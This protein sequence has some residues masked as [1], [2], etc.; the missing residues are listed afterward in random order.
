[1]K[2]SFDPEKYDMVLCPLC[3]GDGKLPEDSGG[4]KICADCG[5][6]GLIKNGKEGSPGKQIEFRD[7][8]FLL[9]E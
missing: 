7:K 8:Q 3:N 1:M 2:K 9:P 6:F 4:A 5:G